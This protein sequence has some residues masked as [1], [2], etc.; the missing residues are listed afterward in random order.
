MAWEKGQSGNPEG[1]KPNKP[2]IEALN[3]AIKQE[4]GKRLRQAAEMLLDAAAAGEQWAIKEL[5]DRT[6]GKP[7]QS[8]DSNTTLSGVLHSK[9]ELV[10]VDPKA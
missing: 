8:V 3:R 1:Y 9:V 6:D 7:N 10:V 5:A 2:F 4:D